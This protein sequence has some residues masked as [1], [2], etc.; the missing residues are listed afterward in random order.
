M[1]LVFK[2]LTE[3]VFCDHF[4]IIVWRPFRAAWLRLQTSE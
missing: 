2:S 1:L 3:A 4:A